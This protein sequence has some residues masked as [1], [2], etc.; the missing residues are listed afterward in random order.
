MR[1]FL[2]TVVKTHTTSRIALCVLLALGVAVAA[3]FLAVPFLPDQGK[4]EYKEYALILRLKHRIATQSLESAY[5]RIAESPAPYHLYQPVNGHSARLLARN[6]SIEYETRF[7]IPKPTDHGDGDEMK[8]D[9]IPFDLV[10]PYLDGIAAI[11]IASPQGVQLFSLLVPSEDQLVDEYA[12]WKVQRTTPREDF[13]P[14][15]STTVQPLPPVPPSSSPV[16]PS[17][18]KQSVIAPE[19]KEKIQQA[20]RQ[21]ETR[22]QQEFLVR[23]RTLPTYQRLAQKISRKE[24]EYIPSRGGLFAVHQQAHYHEII[25][26]PLPLLQNGPSNEKL[27]VVFLGVS[28]QEFRLDELRE[29]STTIVGRGFQM[30]SPFRE[31]WSRMNFWIAT[32][33]GWED[34]GALHAA[35]KLREN[36]PWIDEVIV[37]AKG[38]FVSTAFRN[39]KESFVSLKYPLP[40]IDDYITSENEA[41]KNVIVHAVIHEFAHSF[42]DLADEH[43]GAKVRKTNPKNLQP[44]VGI[45][46]MIKQDIPEL[47]TKESGIIDHNYSQSGLVPIMGGVFYACGGLEAYEQLARPTETSA[48][49]SPKLNFT[50]SYDGSMVVTFKVFPYYAHFGYINTIEILSR[51]QGYTLLYGNERCGDQDQ[52]ACGITDRA[53]PNGTFCYDGLGLWKEALGNVCRKRCGEENQPQC[54]SSSSCPS[55]MGLDQIGCIPPAVE[56]V[57]GDEPLCGYSGMNACTTNPSGT[58][59]GCFSGTI[60]REAICRT[61]GRMYQPS[62][63][64]NTQTEQQNGCFAPFV[65]SQG[66]CKCPLGMEYRSGGCALPDGGRGSRRGPGGQGG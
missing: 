46:C 18:E 5:I 60:N 28:E 26:K 30:Y 39:G 9:E 19:L 11:T 29:L 6:G 3:A 15:F 10:F 53:K 23:S 55:R 13:S 2:N 62:C 42:A 44:Y 7:V 56:G 40:K 65:N 37:L 27:D 33:K 57:V 61:C 45:N 1:R 8:I 24:T 34:R 22:K 58:L 63:D 36:Y 25:V 32:A 64:S 14:R 35:D 50:R 20:Q 21:A 12:Q 49:N 41:T 51:L 16:P 59:N 38:S 17:P 66:N 4:R 31:N 54:Q 43:T 47:W 52:W 48:M